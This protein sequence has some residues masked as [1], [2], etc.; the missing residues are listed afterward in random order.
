MTRLLTVFLTASVATLVSCHSNQSPIKADDTTPIVYS[1][2]LPQ[3]R[4][5]HELV[6]DELN[7]RVLITAGSTPLN[8]GASFE[9]FRDLWS[10]DGVGWIFLGNA[11]NTRSGI[12]MAYDT[13]RNAVFSFG[14]FF[15]N[16]SFNDLRMLENSDWKTVSTLPEMKAAEPGL[17]YD[18]HRD[19]L[20]A[21]GGSAGMGQLNSDTWEWDGISW[22]KFS[23]AGPQGRQAFAMVYDA[24]RKKTVLY[25]GMGNNTQTTFSDTW[26]YDGNQWIK[27]SDSLPGP[28]ISHSFAYDS[29]RGMTVIFGG[30]VNGI[31][32]NDMWGWNG[33]Q[34]TKLSESGPEPRVMGYMAY[35]KVRDRIVLFGGRVGWPNDV[36][37]LWE[38]DGSTWTKKV[39]QQ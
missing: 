37:D 11:G 15:N 19:K 17:V 30:M 3:K 35:D 1:D 28:R 9:F 13:K 29:R 2:S 32:R 26:E 25:G 24:L 6:Y 16:E 18:I 10:Y 8:N 22:K 4:A 39:F 12:R 27:V 36:N 5:H 20:V 23:G 14:G 33:V 38:W 31:F 34:W 7:K 21:F